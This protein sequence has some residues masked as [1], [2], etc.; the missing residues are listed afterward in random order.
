M[1]ELMDLFQKV[2]TLSQAES[3]RGMKKFLNV[4]LEV[5]RDHYLNRGSYE[6]KVTDISDYRNGYKSR[7]LQTRFGKLKL[8]KPQIRKGFDSNFFDRYQRSEKAIILSCAEMYLNGVSTRK[9]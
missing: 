9:V 3:V 2:L 7:T 8:K 6:R 5:E 1:K 4:L